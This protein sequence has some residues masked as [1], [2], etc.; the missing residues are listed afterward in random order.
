MWN[1]KVFTAGRTNQELQSSFASIYP[2]EETVLD[3]LC[4]IK[5][6]EDIA[7]FHNGTVEMTGLNVG[8][9]ATFSCNHGYRLEGMRSLT[10]QL[11][12][13]WS[14]DIPV[15]NYIDCGPP[16]NITN[17]VYGLLNESTSFESKV[18]YKC[19]A[20]YLLQGSH[21]R[22]CQ[23]NDTW[24]NKEPYCQS[25]SYIILPLFPK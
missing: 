8:D 25:K 21:Q 7:D 4:V 12:G 17:G 3:G 24:S 23:S 19:A 13:H 11:G 9:S 6:C 2:E 18:E 20:G 15:C 14:P 5:S 22:E 16:D 1:P 10:C